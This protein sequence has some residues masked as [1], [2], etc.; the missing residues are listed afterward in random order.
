MKAVTRV[1]G[2]GYGSAALETTSSLFHNNRSSIED[3][4]GLCLEYIEIQLFIRG[5]VVVIGVASAR[6]VIVIV[7]VTA[8]SAVVSERVAR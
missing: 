8:V 7:F 5:V 4:V 3:K 2:G 1:T 6:V